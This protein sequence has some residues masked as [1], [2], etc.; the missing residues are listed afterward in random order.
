MNFKK[1]SEANTTTEQTNSNQLEFVFKSNEQSIL[2]E[3]YNGNPIFLAK[4]ICDILELQNPTD[5][6]KKTL[7]DDQYLTYTVYRAGQ[8]REMI[9]VKESGLYALIFQSR[10]PE[11]KKFQKWV[12]DVVLPSI[13]K[14][15]GYAVNNSFQHLLSF[16]PT[17]QDDN[18][19]WYA[20][21]MLCRLCGKSMSGSFK[22]KAV[23][24]QAAGLAKKVPVGKAEHWYVHTNGVNELLNIKQNSI[25]NTIAGL[26]EKGG[27]H[28]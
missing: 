4:D 9:F 12:T 7:D 20:A 6:C 16:V 22:S 23:R 21:S 10:K 11:A 8:N 2:I 17:V 1:E 19:T 25:A 15:G 13:R 18:G 14:T 3:M 27:S 26:I 24:L 28:A 5:I